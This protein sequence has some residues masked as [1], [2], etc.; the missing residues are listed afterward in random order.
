MVDLSQSL[1]PSQRCTAAEPGEA[2]CGDV[3]IFDDVVVFVV[4]VVGICDVIITV[5]L[6]IIDV[7]FKYDVVERIFFHFFV[8]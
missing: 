3:V 8:F 5:E 2:L 1:L 4:V 7:V 6:L